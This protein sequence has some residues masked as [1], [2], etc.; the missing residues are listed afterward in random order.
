MD[1]CKYHMK[2]KEKKTKKS[3]DRDR[4]SWEVDEDVVCII[5]N[6]ARTLD[7]AQCFKSIPISHN[8]P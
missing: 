7:S 1:V 2:E 6:K 5:V 4:I 3:N 8:I